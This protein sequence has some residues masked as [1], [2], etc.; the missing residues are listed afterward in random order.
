MNYS[1]TQISLFQNAVYSA[2]YLYKI[3]FKRKILII[4]VFWIA[5]K[6]AYICFAAESD[7]P[8]R[9]QGIIVLIAVG[10]QNKD[11]SQS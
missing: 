6:L 2:N 3:N 4:T 10:T 8:Y 7:G 5:L 9:E 11:Q 1:Q